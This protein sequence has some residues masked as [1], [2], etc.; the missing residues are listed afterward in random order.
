MK[1]EIIWEA[2]PHTLAKISI[3]EEY[4]KAWFP[5]M[6]RFQERIVYIDGFCGPGEYK[7]G[8]KGSPIIALETVLNHSHSYV[9]NKE[10]IFLF[11]D[12]EKARI[13][14]LSKIIQGY[15]LPV[16]IKVECVPGHFKDTIFDILD[17]LESKDHNLAPAFLFID[18]FG[19]KEASFELIKRFMKNPGCEVLINFMIESVNRFARKKEFEEH[20]DEV[21]GTKEWRHCI[22]LDDSS[23]CFLALYEKQLKRIMNYCWSFEMVDKRN[24]TCY[25][26]FYGT[27][28]QLGLE[29]MKDAMWKI[30]PSG[31]YSFSDRYHGQLTLFKD[32]YD[33]DH[34]KSLYM[35]LGKGTYSIEQIESYTLTMTPYRK[36]H[37]RKALQVMEKEK[38]IDVK[39]PGV[40]GY[41]KEFTNIIIM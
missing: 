9:R 22:G 2:E 21:Y 16:N 41:P 27:N 23:N 34:L 37:V 15:S 8:E 31:D 10:I 40:R 28:H 19:I 38:L 24:K 25:M 32:Y 36:A 12:N 29:K 13:D 39:R 30:A 4:L 17:D 1:K 5:I 35:R 26:L 7:G 33:P 3:V 20:L 18:P 14:N 6:S 11:I